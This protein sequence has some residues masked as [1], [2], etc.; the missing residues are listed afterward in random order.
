MAKLICCKEAG[1]YCDWI[2]GGD[3]PWVGRADTE[4]ELLEKVREHA[5]KD[6]GVPGLP[7]DMLMK[8]K[9]V[10]KDE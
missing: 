3:C 7:Q 9:V 2:A 8:A 10:M 4:D 1:L 6:H 5:E